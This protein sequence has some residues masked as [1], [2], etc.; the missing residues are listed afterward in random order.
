MYLLAPDDY[1][2]NAG[3]KA[4]ILKRIG[5][6]GT[7]YGDPGWDAVTSE[8]LWPWI[9]EDEIKEVFAESNPTP[10]GYTPPNNVAA[11]GFA[12][13]VNGLYGGE[14]TLT[15]YIWEYLGNPCPGNLCNK[16]PAPI[17]TSTATDSGG[18]GGGGGVSFAPILLLCLAVL[19]FYRFLVRIGRGE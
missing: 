1:P 3:N 19:L 2:N 8:D 12:A 7:F 11:R 14:V 9:Y 15:S 4:V 13:N 6:T 18:G 16:D 10:S 17:G 5:V